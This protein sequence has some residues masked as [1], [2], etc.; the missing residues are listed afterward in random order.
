MSFVASPP[1]R[2]TMTGWIHDPAHG[3]AYSHAGGLLTRHGMQE[4]LTSWPAPLGRLTLADPL[5][6]PAALRE[7]LAQGLLPIVDSVAPASAGAQLV[8]VTFAAALTGSPQVIAVQA[9]QVSGST[10]L[11]TT[12][13]HCFGPR[14]QVLAPGLDLGAG[15]C[16]QDVEEMASSC[17]HTM[18]VADHA[19]RWQI[20]QMAASHTNSHASV[21][22]VSHEDLTGMVDAHVLQ[23]EDIDVDALAALQ[24]L[25]VREQR[26]GV[27]ATLIQ[28]T[29]AQ[30]PLPTPETY[31]QFVSIGAQA[32]I[33]LARTAELEHNAL[34]LL[35]QAGDL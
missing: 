26:A 22:A 27:L 7:A 31:A 33:Q 28:Q 30:G 23:L 25:T 2:A 13:M 15:H 10:L 12:L 5:T 34:E 14:L 4:Q 3:W 29:A 16:A 19:A 9:P 32:I 24:P 6:S 8:A 21:L 17:S 35:E 18:L 20:D 11:A 1:V